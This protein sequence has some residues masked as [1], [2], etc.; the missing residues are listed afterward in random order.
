V[1]SI[2]GVTVNS[3]AL[4]TAQEFA[5]VITFGVTLALLTGIAQFVYHKCKKRPRPHIYRWGPFYCTA[6][7][8]PFVM[9]DLTRHLILDHVSVH[10]LLEYRKGC[11]HET[12]VCL[13]VVGVI[14]TIV[15]TY[16][17]F[18]CLFIGSLWNANICEKIRELRAKWRELRREA[19]GDAA[20]GALLAV[21]SGP[22]GMDPQAPDAP[23]DADTFVAAPDPYANTP[24]VIVAPPL[25]SVDTNNTALS[26]ATTAP[27]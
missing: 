17:G 13:T 20:P 8:V 1:V 3:T 15:C 6:L 16:L 10:W 27:A 21:G 12:V 25:E 4:A 26:A 5:H 19:E 2:L 11:G 9:A 14:F 24:L 23:F 18:L 7:A 22:T